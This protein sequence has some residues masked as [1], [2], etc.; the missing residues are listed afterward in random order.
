MATTPLPRVIRGLLRI[1]AGTVA[2]LALLAIGYPLAAWVGSSIPES[3]SAAPPS[4]DAETVQIMVETNGTHTSIVVP[5][6]S[7][8]KDWRESFPSAALSRPDGRMPTH[9]SIGWGE[10]EVFLNVPTWGD[11]EA[12]T[13]LRIATVGGD[14]LVR[15]SHYVRPGA[16]EN[17][18]PLTI[19]LEQY[20]TL[21]SAIERVLPEVPPG[22]TREILRGTYVEDAYYDAEGSYS[23]ANTCNTWVGDTLAEAGVEMGMWTPFA[24]G[25][26]KWIPLPEDA[27]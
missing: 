6:V 1:V 18:R 7:E 8:A 27:D 21:V 9:L 3:G 25:V 14:P 16:S 26:M 20:A 23:L 24:G 17:H 15:V 5:I 12:S 11:L 13:A 22:E 2:V 19:S 4:P 10:R